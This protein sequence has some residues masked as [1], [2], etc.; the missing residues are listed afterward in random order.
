M[1]CRRKGGCELGPG[2]GRF[3]RRR[4]ET[5]EVTGA[6]C[7]RVEGAQAET[8]RWGGWEHGTA[9]DGRRPFQGQARRQRFGAHLG[10]QI[11]ATGTPAT[12]LGFTQIYLAWSFFLQSLL[13]SQSE[14]CI[15]HA[16]SN[17][18]TSNAL[19]LLVLCCAIT[20]SGV[21]W[22]RPSYLEVRLICRVPK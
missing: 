6:R 10:V 13:S 11:T 12:T 3:G 18:A 9:G 7:G 20:V 21:R 17:I 1:L 22:V 5:L 19:E 14:N 16:C 8:G 15:P 4:K 2:D